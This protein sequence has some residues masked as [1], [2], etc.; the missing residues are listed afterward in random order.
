MP[1]KLGNHGSLL[2]NYGI[3]LLIIPPFAAHLL[4]GV[5]AQIGAPPLP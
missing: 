2:L 4:Y 5:E 1:P 3:T